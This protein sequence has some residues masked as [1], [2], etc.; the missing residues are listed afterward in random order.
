ME[1]Y[2]Y[3]R[4]Y[5]LVIGTA[6]APIIPTPYDPI[7]RLGEVDNFYQLFP[8]NPDY[9]VIEPARAFFVNDLQITARI[10]SSTESSGEGGT[11]TIRIYNLP[12]DKRKQALKE[13]TNVILRAGY[14]SSVKDNDASQ[15]PIIYVGQVHS[16]KVIWE[17][18]DRVTILM[19][20]EGFT[21]ASNIRISY[22]LPPLAPQYQTFSEVFYGLADI[23]KANGISS[24]NLELTQRAW[25]DITAP[26]PL[27]Q[28]VEYGWSY[29]GFLQDAMDDLCSMYNY[30][31]Y[32]TNNNLY[33]HHK[34]ATQFQSFMTVS[35]DQLLEV[36]EEQDASKSTEK[37]IDKKPSRI[38]L[39]LLLDGRNSDR[40]MLRITSGDYKGTYVVKARQYALSYRGA[41]WHLIVTAEAV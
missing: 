25:D 23:W 18:A 7:V 8:N 36:H 3:K 21:P 5:S 28:P 20:K 2:N 37:G 1:L 27:T 29:E 13:N 39:K 41:E 15:L 10:A 38:K 34:K 30:V 14:Y 12:E 26:S 40:Q 4:A 9:Q 35:N 22:S 32:I 17:G 11:A 19:C 16:S 24:T 31:W 6:A 33:V